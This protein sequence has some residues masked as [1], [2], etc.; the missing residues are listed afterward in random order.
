METVLRNTKPT[1]K[2]MFLDPRTKILLCLTVSCVMLSSDSLGIMNI[3]LPCLAVIPLLFLI[4]L[5]K[6]QIAA[7]YAVMY[8][9]TA[10]LPRLIMPHASPLFNLMFTGMIAMFTKL[11]PGMSMFCLLVLTTTVSEFV[12]AMDRLHISKKFS[13]PIS[14]MFRFLPTIM[15]EY[16]AIH[17][18]MR[19]REIGSWRNPIEMLE[20]RMVP[21]LTGLVTIG[22]ELSTSA[23]TRGLDAPVQRT[24]ICPIGFHWQDGVALLFC[25]AVI[26]CFILSTFC[27]W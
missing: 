7:Y 21:L 26:I 13:I 20:Y 1:A 23:L 8:A 15:E 18:A 6:P 25:I 12:A 3:V 22:N 4:L 24:N 19:L 14:V 11:I 16:R 5:K 10:T 2:Q 17:D 9:V 27:G